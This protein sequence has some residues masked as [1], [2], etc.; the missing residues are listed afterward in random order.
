V[1]IFGAGIEGEICNGPSRNTFPDSVMTE[2]S[3]LTSEGLMFSSRSS[4]C[5]LDSSSAAQLPRTSGTFAI[6]IVRKT[7]AS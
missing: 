3:C 4:R 2:V 5:T 6:C 1:I 7:L